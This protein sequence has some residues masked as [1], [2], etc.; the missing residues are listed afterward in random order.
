MQSHSSF[1][2]TVRTRLGRVLVP[3]ACVLVPLLA[4][5]LSARAQG[6]II[7]TDLTNIAA[8]ANGGRIISVTSTLDNDKAYQADNLID[9]KVWNAGRGDGSRGWASDKFDPIT[10]DAVT[11]G[12][13]GNRLYR[14]G[15]IV[16]NPATDLT[17]ERWAKDVELQV[18]T[19]SAEGPYTTVAQLT[20]KQRAEAQPFTILPVQARF[21]RL[22]FRTNYGS[23]RAVSL[24]EIQ[25]Y[26]AIDDSD[27]MG[28]VISRLDG[29][30]A[31]LRR[32]RD[33][34]ADA[35]PAARSTGGAAPDAPRKVTVALDNGKTRQIQ[36]GAPGKTNIAAAKNGG[37]VVAF[38]SFYSKDPKYGPD[39]LIDGANFSDAKPDSSWGWASEGFDPGKEYVTLGFAGNQTHLISRFIL[40]PVS[41]QSDL[42]WARRVDVQATTGDPQTGPWKSVT[43]IN[44]KPDATNQEFI[45]RS[46][47]AKYVR[48]IFQAN[49]PGIVLPNGD[50][51][52][53]SDRAVSLGEIE[54]YEPVSSD[55]RLESI[56]GQFNQLSVDLKT[57]R[58]RQLNADLPTDGPLAPASTSAPLV[59][60]RAV[61]VSA[62]IAPVARPAASKPHPR[63]VKTPVKPVGKPVVTPIQSKVTPPTRISPP[64]P[65]EEAGNPAT[66]IGS[67]AG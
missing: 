13:S 60:P 59:K 50:P 31:E 7:S 36:L 21:V 27:P 12:F 46:T 3:G 64:K 16:L 34:Q 18:S 49:G 58:R 26:E 6:T 39:K 23:D 57:L 9:G 25:I 2:S 40:N 38:S 45:I 63:T 28:S 65:V 44:L 55:D 67:K 22:M 5:G 15:K 1:W 41:N 56:L 42:R 52:V 8:A 24:G 33:E 10:M 37:R 32:Y 51:N 66:K 53:N 48:F 14:I 19:D 11:I 61:P 47:E 20:L 17:P 43:T 54:I 62:P 35:D 29:N 4:S 30:I